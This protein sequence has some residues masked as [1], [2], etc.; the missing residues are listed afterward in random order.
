[1]N[2]NA[3]HLSCMERISARFRPAQQADWDRAVLAAQPAA[4][5]PGAALVDH[6]LAQLCR[7]LSDCSLS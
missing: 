7:V 2:L 6:L 1:M 4:A 3:M 5:H